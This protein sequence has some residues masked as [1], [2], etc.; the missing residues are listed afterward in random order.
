MS[1]MLA[2]T[3]LAWAVALG[4]CVPM[5]WQRDRMKNASAEWAD[6][7]RT[8]ADS[9]SQSY[10]DIEII[11]EHAALACS[12]Q[13]G[14]YQQSIAPLGYTLEQAAKMTEQAE[15]QMIRWNRLRLTK[16]TADFDK[17]WGPDPVPLEIK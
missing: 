12:K 4:G 9:A 11:L 3:V 14:A 15:V 10:G 17:A 8:Q 7:Y 16:H 6:C 1:K 13:R 2:L 5:Q